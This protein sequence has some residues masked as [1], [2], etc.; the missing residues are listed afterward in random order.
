[1]SH[2]ARRIVMMITGCHVLQAFVCRP[3]SAGVV[4]VVV[5]RDAY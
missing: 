1:M 4:L 5:E 2:H 3:F